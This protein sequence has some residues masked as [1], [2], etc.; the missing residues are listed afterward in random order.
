MKKLLSKNL[1]TVKKVLSILSPS[2][3]TDKAVWGDELPDSSRH[4]LREDTNRTREPTRHPCNHPHFEGRH[5]L[6]FDVDSL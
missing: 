3:T 4:A 1:L 5:N 2:V 6:A